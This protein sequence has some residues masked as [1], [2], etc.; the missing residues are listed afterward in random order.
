MA[1]NVNANAYRY[2]G[3]QIQTMSCQTLIK[4]KSVSLM[5]MQ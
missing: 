1:R 4:H 3:E 5:K 2:L